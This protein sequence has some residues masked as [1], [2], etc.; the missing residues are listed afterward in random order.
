MDGELRFSRI[1]RGFDLNRE[2]S[3]ETSE[4][5][6]RRAKANESDLNELNRFKARDIEILWKKD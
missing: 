3:R 5:E 6:R 2:K 1:F 4:S